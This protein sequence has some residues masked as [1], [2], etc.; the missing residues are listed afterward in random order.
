MIPKNINEITERNLQSLVDNEVLEGKTLEYKSVLP[1]NHDSDK[2]EFLADVSSFANASGGDIVYGIV[3]DTDTGK[4]TSVEGL[5]V[6]NVDEE[7]QRLDNMIRDGIQPRIPSITIQP[8]T[9]TNPKTAM[10]IRISKSWISPHR[11]TFQGHDKFYS[12]SS[13]GKS[14]MDVG[15]LR[16]AF[17]L[18]E[19]LVDRIRNFRRE[20]LANVISGET[21]VPLPT[22]AKTILHMIPM[23]A[24][25]TSY[26]CEIDRIA[27]DP[28][29][30]PP[31]YSAAYSSGERNMYNFDGFLTY[32][33][34]AAGSY[35]YAQLFRNGAIEAVDTHLLDP[36]EGGYFIH[37]GVY[38]R[39]LV[40]VFLRYVGVLE[41]LDVGLPVFLFLTLTAVKGYR[42]DVNQVRRPELHTI[43][44]DI[45]QLPEILIDSYVVRPEYL[46]KPCFDTVWNACGFA[47]SRN[48]D[49]GGNWAPR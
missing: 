24:F 49:A 48:Y 29:L 42:M 7:I 40:E 3:Q 34:D 9:L 19:T 10:V 14:P 37:S 25:S 39:E 46:L 4:P 6:D 38:E 5:D 15:E 16:V 30:M 27:S 17:N 32:S 8:I 35:S 13:N 11:I 21:P 22:S 33:F 45:L 47:R 26:S 36:H 44:R 12:R 20:R 43:D 2:K 31:I 18:S 28:R 23:S 41:K 1:G